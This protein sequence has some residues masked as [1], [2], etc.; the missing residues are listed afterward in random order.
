M[1]RFDVSPTLFSLQSLGVLKDVIIPN[2]VRWLDGG[3][4]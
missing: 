4:P 2:R 1:I 3:D